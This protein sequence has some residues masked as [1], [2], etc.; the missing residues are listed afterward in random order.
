M[1]PRCIIKQTLG[2]VPPQ[3][4][5]RL[6]AKELATASPLNRTDFFPTTGN[7]IEILCRQPNI[8]LSVPDPRTIH[9]IAEQAWG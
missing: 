4:I 3:I 2:N 9:C 5:Q 8:E 7:A 6:G 1:L